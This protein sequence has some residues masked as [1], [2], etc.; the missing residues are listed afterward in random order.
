MVGGVRK[1]LAL[2]IASSGLFCGCKESKSPA[3]QGGPIPPV[4]TVTST[5]T[6]GP[7]IFNPDFRRSPDFFTLTPAAFRS[8]SANHPVEAQIWYSRNLQGDIAANR[9]PKPVPDGTV[10]ILE[11]RNGA[12]VTL[13]TMTKRKGS[14]PANGDWVYAQ[15]TPPQ[16]LVK[17]AGGREISG[18]V[19]S[20]IQCHKNGADTDYLRGVGIRTVQ[21]TTTA[22]PSPTVTMLGSASGFVPDFATNASFVTRMTQAQ[23]GSEPHG[24]MQIWYSRSLADRFTATPLSAPVGS[25]A[26]LKSSGGTYANTL[27][28]MTKKQAGYDANSGD[29]FY[30]L[31]DGTGSNILKDTRGQVLEGPV[32]GQMGGVQACVTCHRTGGTSTDSLRGTQIGSGTPQPGPGRFYV[33]FATRTD[34]FF[35]RMPQ[36]DAARTP[37]HGKIR[38]WFSRNIESVP[39]KAPLSLPDGTTVIAEIDRNNNNDVDSYL[40]MVKKGTSG[41]AAAGSTWAFE[42]WTRFGSQVGLSSAQVQVCVQCHASQSTTFDWL[43]G[44]EDF[45]GPG[46][47]QTTY[48]ESADYFTLTPASIVGDPFHGNIRIFYSKNIQG[49]LS[50]TDFRAPQGTVAIM[51]SSGNQQGTPRLAV[52]I[53]MQPGFDPTQGDWHYE[54]RDSNRAAGFPIVP[55]PAPGK[56]ATCIN[57][58]RTATATRPSRDFL[59]GLAITAPASP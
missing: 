37:E 50:R 51:E 43:Y 25:V 15:M 28:I 6:P 57:C 56:N 49:L 39:A 14:D 35:T 34:L 20:C 13:F 24:S 27:A 42:E 5:P 17:D 46:I 36:L 21:P 32:N 26:I 22:N 8:D 31:R 9:L 45:R 2:V 55:S 4:A 12:N 38:T 52:M 53:K 58:H 48:A 54:M 3:P 59:R 7:G 19:E 44:V 29:W 23:P 16:T 18:A 1:G 33:D 10:A 30:E 41:G 47:F 11:S 40:V